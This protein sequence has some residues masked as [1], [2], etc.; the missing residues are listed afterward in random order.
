MKAKQPINPYIFIPN[1]LLSV[2]ILPTNSRPCQQFLTNFFLLQPFSLFIIIV[3]A[4]ALLLCWLVVPFVAVVFF[5]F[6]ECDP[7]RRF[8]GWKKATTDPNMVVTTNK[9]TEREQIYIVGCG[10]VCTTV[11][12]LLTLT[13]KNTN[14]DHRSSSVGVV[15]VS[16]WCSVLLFFT[17]CYGVWHSYRL[18]HSIKDAKESML[19]KSHRYSGSEWLQKSVETKGG[20]T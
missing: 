16:P 19:T 2:L 10:V 11:L 8:N 17:S 18:I 6:V 5:L 7:T 3:T 20:L 13:L 15:W 1:F 14:E 12:L 4:I 9:R